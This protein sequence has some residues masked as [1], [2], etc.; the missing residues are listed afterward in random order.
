MQV[1]LKSLLKEPL[2]SHLTLY[3]WIKVHHVERLFTVLLLFFL[4]QAN[5]DPLFYKNTDF[6]VLLTK[7]YIIMC[8]YIYLFIFSILSHVVKATTEAPSK[9]DLD[10]DTFKME[11]YK[12]HVP[13]L[14]T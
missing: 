12:V 9:D 10:K 2:T 8:L 11:D 7:W 1:Q 3:K 14:Q 4:L 6:I 5:V 13:V